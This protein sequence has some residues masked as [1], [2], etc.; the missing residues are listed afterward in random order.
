MRPLYRWSRFTVPLLAGVLCAA[1][2]GCETAEPAPDGVL[3]GRM[4][5]GL[6][7]AD[8]VVAVR[9]GRGGDVDGVDLGVVDQLV[10]VVVPPR[11]A[12]PSGVV[13]GQLTGA[14]HHGDQLGSFGLLEGRSALAF[15]HVPDADDA[16]PHPFHDRSVAERPGRE[17][18][19]RRRTQRLRCRG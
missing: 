12:V 14:A 4:T 13:S 15:G 10:R 9:V 11:D 17:P 18:W 6:R 5:R 1:L 19:P 3:A 2:V 8:R 16:P 7:D